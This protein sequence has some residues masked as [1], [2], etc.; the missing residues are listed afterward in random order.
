MAKPNRQG[1][2]AASSQ[3]LEAASGGAGLTQS[4]ALHNIPGQ[5]LKDSIDKN[6]N[7]IH[8]QGINDVQ[9]GS[10]NSIG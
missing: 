5:N 6:G 9:Q 4:N 1:R 3:E 2:H 7:S 8:G 10:G